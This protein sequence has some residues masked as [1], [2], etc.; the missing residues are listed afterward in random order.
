[1]KTADDR[2]ND[3][4][5]FMD[6]ATVA[7]VALVI[8]ALIIAFVGTWGDADALTADAQEKADRAAAITAAGEAAAQLSHPLPYTASVRDCLPDGTEC[9]R[10]R[11]YFPP[12][13]R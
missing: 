1:M 10:D 11:L 9:S 2:P 6:N 3:A 7:G 12:S 8:L 4:A 5:T 13:E